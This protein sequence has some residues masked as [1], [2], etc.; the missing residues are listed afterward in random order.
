VGVVAPKGTPPWDSLIRKFD[1]PAGI[2]FEEIEVHNKKYSL[3][4]CYLGEG[5][6]GDYDPENPDDAPLL[7]YDVCKKVD[8]EWEPLRNGSACC[9]L[10]ANE[11]R[12]ALKKAAKEMLEIVSKTDPQHLNF[13]VQLLS[14]IEMKK[15]KLI[16]PKNIKELVKL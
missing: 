9:Q 7:R 16:I 14:W 13:V 3:S 2:K 12:A 10:S 8:G 4:F 6:D 15:G 5:A 1:M 11:K